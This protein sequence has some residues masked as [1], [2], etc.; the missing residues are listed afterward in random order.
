MGEMGKK[1][2][3]GDVYRN[4]KVLVTGNTGFKGSW[5]CSWLI[6]LGADV[7]G[8]S[9]DIPSNPSMFLELG[10]AD[11]M[12]H[13][14]ADVRDF[15]SIEKIVNEVAPD[16]LFHLAAQAIVSFSYSE[17][18]DTIS[19][20][21]MGTA[22]ILEVLRKYDKNCT[23]IIITS[24]KCYDNVEWIYGYKET[25]AVGGKDIYSGSKGAAELMFKSYYHSFFKKDG[26]NVRIASAR[27]GNVIGGGDWALDRIIPDCMRSWSVGKVVEIRSPK[28][29][30]PWQHVL[31]PLSGYLQLGERLHKDHSL[32]GE[33]FNFGPKSEYN[34]SVQE[35]LED[36]SVRWH[37][38][39][40]KDAY[41]VTGDIKFYEAGLL[42]L[43]CDKALFHFKWK[44]TLNYKTLIEFTS[45]WYY[46]FYKNKG[47]MFTY[48]K[49]QIEA[50]EDLALAEEIAWTR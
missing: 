30:R 14:V 21:V 36:M 32:N 12:T 15:E 10:L 20:N 27:A 46:E 38:E 25:D 13:Y 42:K 39:N 34:H 49:A 41:I 47:D 19:S 48:T 18:L 4:K 23:G 11:K 43:N 35:I 22:N 50:Y 31:E 28:A 3:F 17:P 24:D 45:D 37:F 6:S 1:I 9:K 2:I 8:I 40:S 44:P 26:V 7:Y 16:F 5:L 33:S 29:T